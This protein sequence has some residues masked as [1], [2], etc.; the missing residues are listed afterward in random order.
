MARPLVHTQ[1]YSGISGQRH[2]TNPKRGKYNTYGNIWDTVDLSTLELEAPIV[3]CKQTGKT[4]KHLA[5]R[6]MN[7]KVKLA[8]EIMRAEFAKVGFIPN[9]NIGCTLLKL[10]RPFNPPS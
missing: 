5:K 3:T 6:R 7:I 8:L 4:Y 2:H 1:H 9:D 10:P